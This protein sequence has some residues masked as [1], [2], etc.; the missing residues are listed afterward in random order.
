ME[1]AYT[2]SSSKLSRKSSVRDHNKLSGIPKPC[3]FY[4]WSSLGHL[5]IWKRK[6]LSKSTTQ[7]N[8]EKNY[9]VVLWMRA[10]ELL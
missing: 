3:A 1:K 4:C 5:V 7:D 9:T 10:K 8:E 6:D 2:Y